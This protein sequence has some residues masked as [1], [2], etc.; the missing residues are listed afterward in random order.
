VDRHCFD[1][2]PDQNGHRFDASP[3]PD[4]HQNVNSDLN[5][6]DIIGL[7]NVACS[8]FCKGAEDKK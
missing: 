1:A 7:F 6:I 3:D 8:N 2:N 4:R 5:L